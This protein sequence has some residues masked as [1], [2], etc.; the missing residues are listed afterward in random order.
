M[1]KNLPRPV[2]T[3]KDAYKAEMTGL[4]L[5]LGALQRRIIGAKIPVMIVFEGWDASGKGTLI[6]KLMM[7]FDPRGY[8]VHSI[9]KPNEE[10]AFRPF[11]WRFWT[12]TP[13]N[14]RIAIFDRSW[15]RR[16]STERVDK[17][18][19]KDECGNAYAD[20]NTFEKQ[21]VDG[22][23][24][25]VKIFLHITRKEQRK[26]F[27]KLRGN[28]ATSWRVTKDDIKHHRQYGKYLK[29]Y[30]EMIKS[31]DTEYASWT[32][33]DSSSQKA[34]ALAIFRLI[35]KKLD[36]AL[37]SDGSSKPVKHRPAPSSYQKKILAKV[38]LGRIL[39]K[40]EY[41]RKLD[42]CQE[43]IRDIEHEIYRKR[44]PVLVLY[45]GWDAAGKGGNIRRLVQS[46][47]PRGYEVVPIA[48]PS[49]IEKRHHY[50]WRFWNRIPKAGHMAIFDRTWYGR[51]LVERVEGF[52]SEKEWR[53]SYGEIN[54]MER[55][56]SSFGAVIV[57]FWLNISNEEQLRRF[58]ER[59]TTPWKQWKITDEDWRN[60][61]KWDLY[62][63]AVDEMIDRTSTSH[64]PWTIVESNCKYFARIKAIETVIGA[65]EKAL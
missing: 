57:K 21:L 51:V 27:K 58:K 2:K 36:K 53:R 64:A 44:M 59:Q 63:A 32:V 3:A 52:C 34:A 4:E 56:I 55:H 49:D 62:S 35:A 10:E 8:N 19:R 24:V 65:V 54:D 30:D 9:S 29:T 48:A 60:R 37:S 23:G 17:D 40:D 46:M 41:L 25:I 11:L 50:Q 6:N 38:D 43:R 47:D 16:V 15:Y 7:S 45:E 28:P 61:E 31:T 13:E 26:R 22:G 14:G 20:I 1:L 5:K 33:V 42:D 18:V 39:Q 12:K